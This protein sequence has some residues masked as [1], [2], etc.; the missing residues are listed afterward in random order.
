MDWC[1]QLEASNTL[2]TNSKLNGI[3]LLVEMVDVHTLM[4][5]SIANC[6]SNLLPIEMDI[7]ITYISIC[8]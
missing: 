5:K 4:D 7:L 8:S 6:M 2:F 3:S 1:T